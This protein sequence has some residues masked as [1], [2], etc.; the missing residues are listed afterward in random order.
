MPETKTGVL[1][2]EMT[3]QVGLGPFQKASYT[4]F[5]KLKTMLLALKRFQHLVQGQIVL[6]ATDYDTVVAYEDGMRSHSLGALL[7]RLFLVQS[8]AD[9]TEGYTYSKS[10]ECNRRQALPSGSGH[11][12]RIAPPA[13]GMRS[14]LSGLISSQGGPNCNQIQQQTTQ[15][16]VPSSLLQGLGSGCSNCV[17][18]GPGSVCLSSSV[19]WEK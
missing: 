15:V 19:S 1:T 18:G 11:S 5:L 7:W 13:R 8:E 6:V 17:L 12:D 16:C 3:Q 10:S 9:C 4:N 14:D 2:L